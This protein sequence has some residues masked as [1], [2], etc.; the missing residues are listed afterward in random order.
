MIQALLYGSVV[1][2]SLGL[3]GGGGSILAVPLLVYGLAFEFRQ[4]VALSLGIVGATSLYGA[5]LHRNQ[6]L[7]LWKQGVALGLGGILGVPL[8]VLLGTQV[9][10]RVALILFAGLMA[11]IALTMLFPSHKPSMP[12]WIQCSGD[13]AEPDVPIGCLS[14]LLV[15]GFVTGMLSGL[16]GV[17][18]GF[19]LIPALMGVAR[20]GIQQAMA[21]SLVAIVIISGSGFVSN[22]AA[23]AQIPFAIP[24]VF[25]GGSALGMTLG[26][27]TKR[28]CSPRT[29]QI[30][31]GVGVLGTA[32]FVLLKNLV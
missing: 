18:G 19:L 8:G 12:R 16:F 29:L 7:V 27:A 30:V 13:L 5:I 20:V 11:Y 22:S 1:G 31:F 15:A 3:T 17:G 4:A 28:F 14:K 26:V 32:V 23:L 9:S 25:F 2:L 6:G 21:T 24:T 10:D